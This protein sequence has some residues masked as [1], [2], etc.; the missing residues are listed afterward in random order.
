MFIIETVPVSI[1]KPYGLF[2][3]TFAL[4][5]VN[6]TI[7]VSVYR[8]NN[9]LLKSVH[10]YLQRGMKPFFHNKT[11]QRNLKKIVSAFQS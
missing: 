7:D 3:L 5:D 6:T 10:P 8:P 2:P 4:F 9:F 1:T 11:D